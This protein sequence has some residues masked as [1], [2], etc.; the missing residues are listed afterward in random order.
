MNQ[1]FNNQNNNFQNQQFINNNNYQPQEPIN[2]TEPPKKKTPIIEL[3]P[4][5]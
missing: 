2:N 5:E 1:E 3:H 4:L